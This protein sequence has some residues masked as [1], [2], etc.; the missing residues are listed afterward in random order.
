LRLHL[1]A[2]VPTRVRRGTKNIT[3]VIKEQAR[4]SLTSKK[5]SGIDAA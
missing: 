4:D 5:D 2:S 1:N 3:G